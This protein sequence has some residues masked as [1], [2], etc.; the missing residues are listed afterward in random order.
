MVLAK[1]KLPISSTR[2][3]VGEITPE[4]KIK[5]PKDL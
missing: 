1:D 4:G 5:S 2:I 3:R